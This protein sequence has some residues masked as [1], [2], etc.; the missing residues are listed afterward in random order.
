VQQ[1]TLPGK[2]LWELSCRN[3]HA[4]QLPQQ[5]VLWV[6]IECCCLMK[7]HHLQLAVRKDSRRHIPKSPQPAQTTVE[8]TPGGR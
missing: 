5:Q 7:G 6:L 4:V 8:T 1:R 3:L 2:R